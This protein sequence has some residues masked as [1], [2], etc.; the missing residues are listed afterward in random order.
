MNLK[1]CTGQEIRL[2][3]GRI[4]QGNGFA[5]GCTF[6]EIRHILIVDEEAHYNIAAN[7]Q[8]NEIVGDLDLIFLNG[9]L[10]LSLR[11]SIA[12]I[13]SFIRVNENLLN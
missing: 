2:A 11:G 4:I 5:V 10:I 12:E 1:N 8:E 9:K 7:V 6:D 3:D 13:A